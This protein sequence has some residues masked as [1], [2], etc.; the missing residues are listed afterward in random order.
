MEGSTD[1]DLKICVY[2]DHQ[3]FDRY[4]KFRIRGYFTKKESISVKELTGLNP[5]DYVVHIDHG[6]G[7]F[8]GLEKDRSERKGSGSDQACL[9]G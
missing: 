6:I 7:R 8:G 3:I 9:Q 2:T 4:H 1:H 5:G